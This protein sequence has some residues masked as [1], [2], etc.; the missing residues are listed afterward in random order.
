[1]TLVLR[2]A[3]L[4][5]WDKISSQKGLKKILKWYFISSFKGPQ[6]GRTIL[7]FCKCRKKEE[8]QKMQ[9]HHQFKPALYYNVLNTSIRLNAPQAPI[10]PHWLV[11]S[12]CDDTKQAEHPNL[13]QSKSKN[14]FFQ[15]FPHVIIPSHLHEG[16]T[17]VALRCLLT[18]LHKSMR[19]W[20]EKAVLMW[21]IIELA[22]KIWGR[23]YVC[24]WNQARLCQPGDWNIFQFKVK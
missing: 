20:V 17:N 11:S 7:S 14:S 2:C 10:S 3:L 8:W 13:S 18:A 22:L 6:Q 4:G 15:Q 9:S 16:R 5:A 24:F 21:L 12:Y 23:H 1:M 19:T